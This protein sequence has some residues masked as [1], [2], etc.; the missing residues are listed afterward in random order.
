[1][2]ASLPGC[3]T[4]GGPRAARF[5]CQSLCPPSLTKPGSDPHEFKKNGEVDCSEDSLETAC[6]YTTRPSPHATE[7]RTRRVSKEMAEFSRDPTGRF[8]SA[9][10]ICFNGLRWHADWGRFRFTGLETAWG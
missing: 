4:L 5:S 9:R 8:V 6:K 7:T 10:R 2:S 3:N 1:M